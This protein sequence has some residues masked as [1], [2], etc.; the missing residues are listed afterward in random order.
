M[1]AADLILTAIL[2][3]CQTS[4]PMTS[5]SCS[6]ARLL[7]AEFKRAFITPI[8]KKAGLSVR[9]DLPQT[10]LYSRKCLNAWWPDSSWHFW[11]VTT[12]YHIDCLVFDPATQR[13]QPYIEI[14]LTEL[15]CGRLLHLLAAVEAVD[16]DVLRLYVW[17][18]R[19]RAFM[20]VFL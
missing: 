9:V 10:S 5:Q 12:C 14:V 17:Y 6:I 19:L 4:S 13:R 18:F 20:V 7:P 8:V 2:K 16:N 15:R 11:S 3:R 1:S